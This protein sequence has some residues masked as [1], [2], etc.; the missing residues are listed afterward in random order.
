MEM[1]TGMNIAFYMKTSIFD[2]IMQWLIL[3]ICGSVVIMFAKAGS[4]ILL[5]KVA[6]RIVQGTRRDLYESI[7]RK[8]VGWHDD[9]ENSSGVMTATLSS[10]VQTLNGVSSDGLAVMVE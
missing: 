2:E 3:M 5:S 1:M 10:D 7:L 4:M 9:K 8:N 6:E